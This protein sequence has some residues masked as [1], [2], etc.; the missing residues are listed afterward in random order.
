MDLQGNLQHTIRVQFF[1]FDGFNLESIAV[2]TNIPPE[3]SGVKRYFNFPTTSWLLTMD[4]MKA[5]KSFFTLPKIIIFYY[6]M[7]RLFRHFCGTTRIEFTKDKNTCY[8]VFPLI[9]CK[10]NPCSSSTNFTEEPYFKL[11]DRQFAIRTIIHS[12]EPVSRESF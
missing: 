10:L 11:A 6:S 9:L 7:I 2:A 8:C 12:M 1:C 3:C 5:K 4:Q